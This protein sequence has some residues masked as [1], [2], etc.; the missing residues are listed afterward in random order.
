MN[1]NTF[2]RERRFAAAA[3][4]F[5]PPPT[6]DRGYFIAG[7]L[8]YFVLGLTFVKYGSPSLLEATSA[9]FTKL[10]GSAVAVLALA[11]AISAV[12]D[13]WYKVEAAACILLASVMAT[14]CASVGDTLMLRD[15]QIDDLRAVFGV[16]VFIVTAILWARG[17][18]LLRRWIF[19]NVTPR[20]SK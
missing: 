13:F 3:K 11:G 4:F 12:R 20:V 15:G 14:Y 18:T 2:Q 6:L 9:D 1:E 17:L 7:Y 16:V 19:T 5:A 10:L 8:L